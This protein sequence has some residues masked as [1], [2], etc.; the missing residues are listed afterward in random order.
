MLFDNLAFAMGGVGGAGGGQGNPLGA[1]VPL[2]L[3]FAIFYF[4]LIRPQQKKAKQHKEMIS[5]LKIGDRIVTNGGLYGNIVRMT[6]MTLIVEIADK[7]QVEML[8]NTVAD[9]AEA[10]EKLEKKGK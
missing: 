6:D 5:N 10:F 1:F 3:M 4:L 7:V 9:K 8:R 2:I